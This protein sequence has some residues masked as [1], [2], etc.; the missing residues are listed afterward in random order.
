M[1][2]NFKGSHVE[3]NSFGIAYEGESGLSTSEFSWAA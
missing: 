2:W 3:I 1:S